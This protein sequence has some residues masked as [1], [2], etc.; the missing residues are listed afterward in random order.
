MPYVPG[1]RPR[2]RN[3][4]S[5]SVVAVWLA[6][7]PDRVTVA[8]GSGAPL[9]SF[10]LPNRLP[11]WSWANAA[12]ASS[13]T[14]RNTPRTFNGVECVMKISSFLRSFKGEPKRGEWRD[15]AFLATMIGPLPPPFQPF[16]LSIGTKASSM[17]RC[18]VNR[19]RPF[20]FNAFDG[21]P[22]LLTD[23]RGTNDDPAD[24]HS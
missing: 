5:A 10:A 12:P 3:W 24:S 6:P 2:K 23:H 9:S 14:A 15:E 8:P 11:L 7:L 1:A 17:P 20:V 22:C 21:S 13:T 16:S 4:P 18:L 19:Y